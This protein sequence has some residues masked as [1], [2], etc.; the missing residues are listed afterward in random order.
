MR[1]S[2]NSLASICVLLATSVFSI[3]AVAGTILANDGVVYIEASPSPLNT[4]PVTDP[5]GNPIGSIAFGGGQILLE[6]YAGNPL[7]TYDPNPTWWNAPGVAYTTT[8]H[9]IEISFS[10]LNVTGFTFNIGANQN[11]MAWIEAYYDDGS[12]NTLK[13]G[14]T[15]GIGPSSTP[16]YGVYVSQPSVSCAVITK[17]VVDPTFEWGIGNFGIAESSCSSVPEPGTTN[18]FGMG[19]LAIGFA[20]YMQSTRRKKLLVRNI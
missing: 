2:T 17:I 13:T 16:S 11:A 18:L 14:W 9:G 1:T 6:D 4:T 3:S 5:I 7:T 12:G 15:G 19:L 10:N 8:T 20:Q